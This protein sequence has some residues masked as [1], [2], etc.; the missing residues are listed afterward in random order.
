MLIDDAR[1]VW[2]KLW[3][4]RLNLLAAL[5]SSVEAVI[6]LAPD[7]FVAKLGQGRFALAA[8]VVSLGA[9]FARIVKQPKLHKDGD[10]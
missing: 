9:A 7:L 8:L 10:E 3:S 5:L 2:Y 6:H 1:R 4:L